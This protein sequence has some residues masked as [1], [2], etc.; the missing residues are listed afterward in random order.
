MILNLGSK[1]VQAA[2]ALPQIDWLWWEPIGQSST[3][4]LSYLCDHVIPSLPHVSVAR[5]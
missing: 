5:G 1:E 4:P 3:H 2:F